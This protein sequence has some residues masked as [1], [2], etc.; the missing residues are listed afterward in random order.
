M[1]K[2]TKLDVECILPVLR[3]NLLEHRARDEHAS[4]NKEREANRFGVSTHIIDL[5]A[6]KL[7]LEGILYTEVNERFYSW[8]PS[9]YYCRLTKE[10]AQKRL[11]ALEN[12]E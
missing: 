3:H 11:K 2:T 1:K 8:R 9:F 5:V 7:V 6:K 10:Q 12:P 4:I